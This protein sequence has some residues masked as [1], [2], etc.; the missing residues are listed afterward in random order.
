MTGAASTGHGVWTRRGV[1][2]LALNALVILA[3]PF[4]GRLLAPV[5]GVQLR[6][7][8]FGQLVDTLS[9]A[10][11]FTDVGWEVASAAGLMDRAQSMYESIAVLGPVIGMDAYDVGTH[12]HPPTSVVL[13]VPLTYLD[14][15]WWLGFYVA[16]SVSAIAL[17]MRVMKVPA[18]VAYPLA[19]LVCL[20]PTGIFSTTTTY[21]LMALAL[22]LAW[23]YRER[24]WVA[25]ASY[26]FLTASRGIAGVLV[27]YPL[28]RR[29]WRTVAVA[30]G[31]VVLLAVLAFIAEPQSFADFWVK[32][33]ES[34]NALLGR[35]YNYSLDSIL[36]RLGL[37]RWL[38]WLAAAC[39]VLAGLARRR[40][41]FWLLAWL[42]FAL[43]PLAWAHS[44]I[45]VIPLGVVMWQSGPLG[46]LLTAAT[47]IVTFGV[48]A[49]TPL[50]TNAGWPVML[51]LTG[52]AVIACPLGAEPQQGRVS[53]PAAGDGTQARRTATAS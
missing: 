28:V 12:T 4:L 8:G 25:G 52:V 6:G 17:S 3:V 22:A 50:G 38:G 2:E 42:T 30:V 26:G 44:L 16:L 5:L 32:G 33:Q 48:L 10:S 14:Y 47:A 19:L 53:D 21:P 23:T 7:W 45:G 46:R 37:P 49:P 11:T 9:G 18:W 34:I 31:L 36:Q 35:D 27:I 41:L 29:Q 20:T 51:A 43:S 15:H 39:V 40:E 13:W 1:V 24:P